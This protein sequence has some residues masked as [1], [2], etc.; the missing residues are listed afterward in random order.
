[1]P[2]LSDR[3]TSTNS[4]P[5]DY[6]YL[7]NSTETGDLRIKIEDI[8]GQNLSPTSDVEF[9]NLDYSGL[10]SYGEYNATRI[11]NGGLSDKASPN[12]S[13]LKHYYMEINGNYVVA[14]HT[15]IQSTSGV[16]SLF[17]V[18]SLPETSPSFSESY[19]QGTIASDNGT[20]EMNSDIK[21]TG[22]RSVVTDAAASIEIYKNT[23]LP[24][25]YRLRYFFSYH[26]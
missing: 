21:I 5:D 13:V 12:T 16:G 2:K 19:L 23:S 18:V 1:M 3:P 25:I 8:Y 20:V 15:N 22:Y 10:I 7:M 11:T 4:F 26:L 17:L 24:Y 6:M 14:G 9:N